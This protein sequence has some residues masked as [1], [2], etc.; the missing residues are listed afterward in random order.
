[1][2]QGRLGPF[3]KFTAGRAPFIA[4]LL[5]YFFDI[6]YVP[7]MQRSPAGVALL[8][9][10]PVTKQTVSSRLVSFSDTQLGAIT[11]ELIFLLVYEDSP[12]SWSKSIRR[13][14]HLILSRPVG[15]WPSTLNASK[16]LEWPPFPDIAIFRVIPFSLQEFAFASYV[17]ARWCLVLPRV[18][19]FIPTF[20]TMSTLPFF[21]ISRPE[22]ACPS[23]SKATN[24]I[25]CMPSSAFFYDFLCTR[26]ILP[27]PE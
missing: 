15:M 14:I 2:S 5:V 20:F 27:F 12:T 10:V 16:G 23:L 19:V 8:C 7:T 17:Y 18:L 24:G 1:M 21:T 26:L 22:L 6:T 3:P 4:R 9:V 13:P 25:W 11:C